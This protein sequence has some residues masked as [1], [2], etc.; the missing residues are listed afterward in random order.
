MSGSARSTSQGVKRGWAESRQ[1]SE[2][3]CDPESD[4]E[5]QAQSPPPPTPAPGPVELEVGC[6]EE[7]YQDWSAGQNWGTALQRVKCPACGC[8][9]KSKLVQGMGQQARVDRQVESLFTHCLYQAQ[10]NLSLHK[11]IGWMIA[12]L[13]LVVVEPAD[14]QGLKQWPSYEGY[15]HFGERLC[16]LRHKGAELS[17]VDSSFLEKY[18]DGAAKGVFRRPGPR[19]CPNGER[20][21]DLQGRGAELSALDSDFLEEYLADLA[22]G[23]FRGPGRHN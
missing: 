17:D 21:L 14:V 4:E 15:C 1:D 12:G 13:G 11:H 16:N 3:S 9:F 23:F 19:R 2:D 7:G 5:H 10:V 18:L 8:R 6:T 20:L 22:S